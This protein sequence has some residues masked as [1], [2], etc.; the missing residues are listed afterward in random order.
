MY[1]L[2]LLAYQCLDKDQ[3]ALSKLFRAESTSLHQALRI[4]FCRTPGTVVEQE[5]SQIILYALGDIVDDE[6][7]FPIQLG[8]RNCV[9]YLDIV[10]LW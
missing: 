8:K 3:L 6:C 10:G 4:D 5:A 2:P 9:C 1:A 7:K